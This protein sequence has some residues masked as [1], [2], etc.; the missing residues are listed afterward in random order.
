MVAALA[1][2]ATTVPG[3]AEPLPSW[4]CRNDPRTRCSGQVA[5]GT[6]YVELAGSIESASGRDVPAIWGTFFGSHWLYVGWNLTVDAGTYLQVSG[7][8]AGSFTKTTDAR[9]ILD[10][11]GFSVDLQQ[12]GTTVSRFSRSAGGSI[13]TSFTVPFDWLCG[14]EGDQEDLDIEVIAF[15][16][17]DVGPVAGAPLDRWA[18]FG[19]RVS[20]VVVEV[21]PCPTPA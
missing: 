14:T 9:T 13:G 8:A 1:Q 10:E 4:Y 18:D 19:V 3:V 7:S 21:L 15:A 17:A 5:R 12:S 20:D 2:A 16:H 11:I 6:D